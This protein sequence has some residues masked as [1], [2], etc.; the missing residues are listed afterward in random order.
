MRLHLENCI[1]KAINFNTI[2][3]NIAF[4][5]KVSKFQSFKVTKGAHKS[6]FFVL[7]IWFGYSAHK[8]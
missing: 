7:V 2:V 1:F 4:K 3:F 5:V 6:A 8:L